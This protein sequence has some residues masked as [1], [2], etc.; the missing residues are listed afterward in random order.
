MIQ[1]SYVGLTGL[2]REV[3]DIND[4][5]ELKMVRTIEWESALKFFKNLKFFI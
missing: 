5:E 3:Y 1:K 2:S 4:F